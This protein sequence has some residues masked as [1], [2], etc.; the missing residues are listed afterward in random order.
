MTHDWVCDVV[1]W[2]Q[3]IE[4]NH[5]CSHGPMGRHRNANWY[6]TG[7]ATGRWLQSPALLII[8]NGPRRGMAQFELSTHFLNFCIM[9]C[10]ALINCVQRRL[11]FLHFP[12]LFEKLVE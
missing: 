12:M 5:R 8:Q 1:V 11:E 10:Q 9:L 3:R 2:R 4:R 7:P 6:P